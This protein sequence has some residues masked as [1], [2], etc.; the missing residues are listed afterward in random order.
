MSIH[1]VVDIDPQGICDKHNILNEA[2][3]SHAVEC[4]GNLG[5][6][7]GVVPVESGQLT[8]GWAQAGHSIKY[9]AYGTNGY[10][11]A[12]VQYYRADFRHDKGQAHWDDALPMGTLT[13][14]IKEIIV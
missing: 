9:D 11:Y 3:Y 14:M 5:T 2:F 1:V 8:G 4:V 13:N 12:G 7:A 10:D 6:E